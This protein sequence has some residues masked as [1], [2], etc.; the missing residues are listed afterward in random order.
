[1]DIG[2]ENRL[3]SELISWVLERKGR[4]HFGK[5]KVALWEDKGDRTLGRKGRTLGKIRSIAF[6][7]EKG[8]RTSALLNFDRDCKP[9]KQR[10]SCRESMS[11]RT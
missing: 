7:E 8:D 9:A 5:D 10:G 2:S 3:Y 1:M 11:N 6:W 4:S